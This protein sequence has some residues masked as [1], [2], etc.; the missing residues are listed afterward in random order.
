MR[1]DGTESAVGRF[2]LPYVRLP[3]STQAGEED[4]DEDDD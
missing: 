3:G 1:P 4:D 2:P